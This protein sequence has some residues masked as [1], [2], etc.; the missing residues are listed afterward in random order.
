VARLDRLDDDVE[1]GLDASAFR[2]VGRRDGAVEARKRELVDLLDQAVARVS[3]AAGPN[4]DAARDQVP[5]RA[6]S[7]R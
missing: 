3:L 1:L 4:G 7:R 6:A 2:R 5:R